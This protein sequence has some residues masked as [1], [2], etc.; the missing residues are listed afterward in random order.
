MKPD[1]SDA[2]RPPTPRKVFD[3]MRPGK[4]LASPT[5]RP[6]I[7]GHKVLDSTSGVGGVGEGSRSLSRHKKIEL[8]PSPEAPAKD[9][10]TKETPE[11]TTPAPEPSKPAPAPE[12]A[13]PAGATPVP[14]VT[15]SVPEAPE[16]KEDRQPPAPAPAPEPADDDP[17]AV[18]L[19]AGDKFMPP[20]QELET[21]K[22]DAPAPIPGQSDII[23]GHHGA[24][25]APG[26]ALLLLGLIILLALVAFNILL[27]AGI[28]TIDGIPHTDFFK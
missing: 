24:I 22:D 27:D 1:T 5:S 20:V 11:K 7:A 17:M 3:V 23:V 16:K 10:E 13:K 12:T 6:V 15:A 2:K 9:E 25:D 26:Q 18:H 28:V 8:T 14:V 21:S 4:A 19:P